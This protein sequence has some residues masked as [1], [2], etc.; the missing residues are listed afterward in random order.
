MGAEAVRK[1]KV[2]IEWDPEDEVWVT[3][4]PALG[5]LSTYGDTR[6]GALTQTREAI[7]GF[8]EAALKEGLPTPPAEAETE[9]VEFEVATP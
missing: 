9:I 7:L 1:F 2:L 6:E 4:V 3:Y 5:H 8:F